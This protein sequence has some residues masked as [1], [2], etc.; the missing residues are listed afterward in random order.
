MG[1]CCFWRIKYMKPLYTLRLSDVYVGQW[2][3]HTSTGQIGQ[4]AEWDDQA[5]SF[6]IW[7][8]TWGEGSSAGRGFI[9]VDN[10]DNFR[11]ATCLEI[12]GYVNGDWSP[13]EDGDNNISKIDPRDIVTPHV[14]SF[15]KNK[16]MMENAE[17][18]IDDKPMHESTI[19]LES[20]LKLEQ[21]TLDERVSAQSGLDQ[22]H[23]KVDLLTQQLIVLMNHLGI[24]SSSARV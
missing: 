21:L 23:A 1:F 6:R 17:K 2:A 14:P 9:V 24:K 16:E 5:I 4:V 12:S 8:G 15:T 19:E 22:L 18:V 13:K 20:N 3:I 10:K 11:Q 7:G